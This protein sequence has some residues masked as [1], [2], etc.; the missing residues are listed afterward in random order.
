[1]P[2]TSKN[3]TSKPKSAYNNVPLYQISTNMENI[4]FCLSLPKITVFQLIWR[5]SDFGIKFVQKYVNNKIFGKLNIKF[6][7][8]I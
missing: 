2:N 7:M 5:T 8:R 1:M 4:R 6:E 3:Y